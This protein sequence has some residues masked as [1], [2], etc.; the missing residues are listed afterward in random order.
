MKRVGGTCF[1]S[2]TPGKGNSMAD[3]IHSRNMS[4]QN[5]AKI[6]ASFSSLSTEGDMK[7]LG[8]EDGK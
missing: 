5:I 1:F 3:F 4:M 8:L 6:E 7:L 2:G